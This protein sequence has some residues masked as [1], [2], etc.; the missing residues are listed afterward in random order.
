[1]SQPITFGI[2][3]RPQH[4]TWAVQ[5]AA[6]PWAEAM[7]FDSIWL[8]D[9]F[10]SLGDTID[11]DAF[12]ASTTLAA[13][14]LSTSRVK[15]GVLTYGNTHRIPTVL[16]K[17]LV[18]IDHMSGGGRVIM[19]IG[20]GWHESEHAAY[21]I[22]FPSA[23]DRVRMLEEALDIY[24]LLET[25]DRTTYQGKHYSLV[26]APFVPKPVNGRLPM[27]IG[28]TKPKMLQ[29]I[30]KHADIWDSSLDLDEYAAALKTIREHARELGRDP[31]SI[32]ASRGVWNGKVDD[33][34]FADV[35]R[36]AHKAGVRQFLFR[37]GHER[38][39]LDEIPRLMESIVPELRA[40][41]ER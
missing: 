19:G 9:H 15:I 2:G 1:M 17:Q 40:E 28:G 7:G 31:E 27:L 33:K 18:T 22:P 12:E 4:A 8:N 13:V 35:V 14:A 24:R 36:A 23:G 38:A 39:N 3:L 26:D 11:A 37:P 16:A 6:W 41:L 20:A 5:A 34:V 25:Q 10:H 29:V 30:G 32:V 21:A